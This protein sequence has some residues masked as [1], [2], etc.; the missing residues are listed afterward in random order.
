MIMLDETID[1][2][3]RDIV[4]TAINDRN[5]YLSRKDTAIITQ[6]DGFI[7][8]HYNC[9]SRVNR[10]ECILDILNYWELDNND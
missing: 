1:N 5:L 10:A 9:M 3:K 7:Q 2:W 6:L 8:F 4:L